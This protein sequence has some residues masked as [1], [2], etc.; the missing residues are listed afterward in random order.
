MNSIPGFG[1]ESSCGKPVGQNGVLTDVDPNV[2]SDIEIV[3]RLKK[4]GYKSNLHVAYYRGPR[5]R[6]KDGFYELYDDSVIELIG[7]LPQKN[8]CELYVKYKLDEVQIVEGVD[9]IGELIIPS[10]F[11]EAAP[12]T[13]IEGVESNIVEGEISVRELIEERDQGSIGDQAEGV[14]AEG[15]VN[16]V[17]E[18]PSITDTFGVR[19]EVQQQK[20]SQV[21]PEDGDDSGSESGSDILE[22]V[23]GNESENDDPELAAIR[24][25]V[26][27]AK[28]NRREK[29]KSI[30]LQKN[31]ESVM[32]EAKQ[33]KEKRRWKNKGRQAALG[34]A[35]GRTLEVVEEGYLTYYPSSDDVCSIASK[36]IPEYESDEDGDTMRDKEPKACFR[37]SAI[38]QSETFD[39]WKWFLNLL[40]EDL[41]ITDGF[42]W[43]IISDQQKGKKRNVNVEDVIGKKKRRPQKEKEDPGSARRTTEKAKSMN[44]LNAATHSHHGP[45]NEALTLSN[46]ERTTNLNA[47]KGLI[48]LNMSSLL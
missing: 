27:I 43:A 3:N 20:N 17:R 41:N 8:H 44:E 30:R 32:A 15:G 4:L 11:S 19:Y 12:H 47:N 46:S 48:I 37:K 38:V 35:S 40:K 13:R 10:L 34:T 29:L 16:V 28:K 45:L 39:T 21:P 33:D 23:L 9:G 1:R 26:Q 24:D 36:S 25:Q 31:L 2:L 14:N 18:E 42:G 5:K 6:L 7:H 22:D